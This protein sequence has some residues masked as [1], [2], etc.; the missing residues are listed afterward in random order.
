MKIQKYIASK[1]SSH[2]CFKKHWAIANHRVSLQVT[3]RTLGCSSCSHCTFLSVLPH[4]SSL[5]VFLSLSFLTVKCIMFEFFKLL[6]WVAFILVLNHS[7]VPCCINVQEGLVRIAI[8]IMYT[9]HR[10]HLHADTNSATQ[11]KRASHVQLL[12]TAATYK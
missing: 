6:R 8:Y 7:W 11:A 9:T 1:L 12:I 10:P 4:N 2:F 3:A 5:Y